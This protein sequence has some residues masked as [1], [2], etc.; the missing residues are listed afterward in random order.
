MNRRKLFIKMF[1]EIIKHG[2][3]DGCYYCT[4]IMKQLKLKENI[5][6]MQKTDSPIEDIGMKKFYKEL[7]ECSFTDEIYFE[8]WIWFMMHIARRQG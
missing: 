4:E 7:S 3:R 2:E 6:E 8:S 5:E 1:K